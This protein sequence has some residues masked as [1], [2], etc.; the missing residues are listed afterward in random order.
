MKIRPA[1]AL[2]ALLL[3]VGKQEV[4]AQDRRWD[5][6]GGVPVG[7]EVARFLRVLQ[8]AG[9]APH[10]P[11]TLRGLTPGEVSRTLPTDTLYPW[12]NRYDLTPR[13]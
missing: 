13:A 7:T 8:V 4:W 6:R 3:V 12:K 9:M 5:V 11:W 1:V 2:L 10:Y